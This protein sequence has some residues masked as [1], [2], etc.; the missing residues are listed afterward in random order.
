VIPEVL[1]LLNIFEGQSELVCDEIH[2]LSA[3][4]D[5]VWVSHLA[6]KSPASSSPSRDR[7]VFFHSHGIACLGSEP[8]NVIVDES[9]RHSDALLQHDPLDHILTSRCYRNSATAAG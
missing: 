3:E 6:N 2:N 4:L 5:S 7:V 1:K 8:I 9:C